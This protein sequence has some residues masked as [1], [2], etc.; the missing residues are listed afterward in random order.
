V[1]R[2]LGALPVIDWF[3]ARLGLGELLA[4]HRQVV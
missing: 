4:G 1:T 3:C 2:Q